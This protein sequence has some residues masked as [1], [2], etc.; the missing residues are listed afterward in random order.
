[1]IVYVREAHPELLREGNRTG[2]V[3]NPKDLKERIILATQCVSQY[4]FT[5]P[6]VIDA[7]DGKVNQDYQA[8]PVRV[9]VVDI[10]GKVAFYAGRGPA[11][12]RIPPVEKT[13]Q[14]LVANH[15]RLPPVPAPQWGEPVN[16][17]RCGLSFD[18]QK[19][20]L[21]EETAIVLRFQNVSD[22]PI[23]LAYDP[24]EAIKHITISGD[25]GP[26][27]RLEIPNADPASQIDRGMLRRGRG[28]LLQGIRP[29][30]SFESETEARIVAAPGAT[31]PVTGTFRASYRLEATEEMLPQGKSLPRRPLWTGKLVSGICTLEVAPRA[32]NPAA[33]NYES[34]SDPKK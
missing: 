5:I 3:G 17:L 32:D 18:P 10:D 23:A 12:F 1:V 2:I 14:K 30:Q 6:M 31:A 7:M 13:L 15:G 8:A 26:A 11:D 34:R 29:G 16:G 4:K 9:T 21:G 28:M 20:S 19:L 25:S 33:R 27:L 24:A 22:R